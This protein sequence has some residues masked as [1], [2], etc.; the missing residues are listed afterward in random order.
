MRRSPCRMSALLPLIAAAA[1]TLWNPLGRDPRPPLG[2]TVA[3][4]VTAEILRF[5]TS[6]PTARPDGQARKVRPRG[7]GQVIMVEFE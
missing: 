6:S 5:E 1:A 3:V 4:P 2:V 7:N